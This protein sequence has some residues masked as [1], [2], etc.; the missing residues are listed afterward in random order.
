MNNKDFISTFLS[1]T[2]KVS[3]LKAK[4]K[5]FK[6]YWSVSDCDN[7]PKALFVFG[8]NDIKKGC[9]GQAIIRYCDNAFG[10][11]TKKYPNHRISSYYADVD[12]DDNIKKIIFAIE[13]LIKKT[14]D[15]DL[16][17]FPENGFGTG[18]SKMQLYAPKTLAYMNSIIKDCFDIDYAN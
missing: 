3:K 11:P 1:D 8:D 15:Y 16:I 13:N 18:L 7:M 6:G 14:A 2:D 17:M 4:C 10:I 5:I 9:G 12:Y